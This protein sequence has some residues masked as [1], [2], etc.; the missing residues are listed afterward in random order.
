M[1]PVV[2]AFRN[3]PLV[4]LA[5]TERE[6]NMH[7]SYGSLLSNIL[8]VFG[9]YGYAEFSAGEHTLYCCNVSTCLVGITDCCLNPSRTQCCHRSISFK[10]LL[11]NLCFLFSTW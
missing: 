7:K 5:T 2:D 8:T 11:Y 3:A 4:A 10:Y 9:K 1:L 6:K